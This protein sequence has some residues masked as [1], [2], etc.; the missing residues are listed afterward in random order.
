MATTSE[1]QVLFISIP[2]LILSFCSF[3]ASC[4]LFISCHFMKR[5]HDIRT[6]WLDLSSSRLHGNNGTRASLSHVSRQ[7]KVSS[8]DPLLFLMSDEYNEESICWEKPALIM[9]HVKYMSV[10]DALLSLFIFNRYLL[11]FFNINI[12]NRHISMI[13]YQFSLCGTVFWY[14]IISF[15]LFRF[16]FGLN[17]D[18]NFDKIKLFDTLFVSVMISICTFLPSIIDINN[19]KLFNSFLYI[20][21][22]II[23]LFILFLLL[24]VILKWYKNNENDKCC[25]LLNVFCLKT[26]YIFGGISLND[27]KIVHRLF[28]FSFIFICI[29]IIPLIIQLI[30]ITTTKS[31]NHVVLIALNEYALSLIGSANLIIWSRSKNFRSFIT[32]YYD[33]IEFKEN[34]HNKQ[35]IDF[36][37]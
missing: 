8:H 21:I 26:D 29:W 17:S 24:S 11:S 28:V 36:N 25:K 16:V 33:I 6:K 27:S 34:H 30:Q 1:E 4:Y 31:I 3:L 9:H 14:F 20:P 23:I 37:I 35:N 19:D 18:T 2:T 22:L 5:L 32:S 7:S 10:F 13:I 15:N 12:N